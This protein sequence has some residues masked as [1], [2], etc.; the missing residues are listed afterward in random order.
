M[1]SLFVR[2]AG[3]SLYC[4]TH[5]TKV[6]NKAISWKISLFL[7]PARK[8]SAWPYWVNWGLHWHRAAAEQF[9]CSLPWQQHEEQRSRS[10]GETFI[11]ILAIIQPAEEVCE[12]EAPT[13]KAQQKYRR[14]RRW[15]YKQW[16]E[17]KRLAR[18][19]LKKNI[20]GLMDGQSNVCYLNF[21]NWC[22]DRIKCSTLR[23]PSEGENLR[24]S[25]TTL[26]CPLKAA[27]NNAVDPSL[28]DRAAEAVYRFCVRDSRWM[29]IWGRGPSYSF[30]STSLINS[31]GRAYLSVCV[32]VGTTQ[33]QHLHHLT[34]AHLSRHPQGGSTILEH[35]QWQRMG[36][37]RTNGWKRELCE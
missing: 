33:E 37:W 1:W 20:T 35:M 26:L 10:G 27:L 21:F 17:L 15:C 31:T 28:N 3:I 30:T 8:V 24:S 25:S 12:W 18:M 23:R 13:E 6:N 32:P 36:W 22:C 4:K 9:E 29:L 7:K 5:K 2:A 14:K 11:S 34:V 19:L 16:L